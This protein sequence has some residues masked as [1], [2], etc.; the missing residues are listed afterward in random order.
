MNALYDL[1][2]DEANGAGIGWASGDV[3][4]LLLNSSYTF[5][6]GHENLDD[7]PVAA[8]VHITDVLT[9]RSSVN[10]YARAANVTAGELARGNTVTQLVLFKDTGVEATSRLLAHIDTAVGLPF[11]TDGGAIDLHWDAA[12]LGPWRI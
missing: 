12:F 4:L 6:A 5:N 2:R 8:R 11:D 10:G 3:K 9:D 1:T 7:I